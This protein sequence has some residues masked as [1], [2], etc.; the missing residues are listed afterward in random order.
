MKY[1]TNSILTVVVL[2]LSFTNCMEDQDYKQD[3]SGF[4]RQASV[5]VTG[6]VGVSVIGTRS[7]ERVVEESEIQTSD[8]KYRIKM[9][10]K[11]AEWQALDTLHLRTA[12]GPD[13]N[14]TD[15]VVNWV[16][17]DAI[18]IY[19]RAT[20]GLP[21]IN[22]DRD[23][24]KYTTTSTTA[25]GSFTPSPYT[26]YYPPK[27][28]LNPVD[29]LAYYPYAYVTAPLDTSYSAVQ[30]ANAAAMSNYTLNYA[31]PTNQT[32]TRIQYADLMYATPV[33]NKV[34]S[35]PAVA[36]SFNHALSLFTFRFRST[37]F[38]GINL[39]KVRLQGTKV[40][41]TG[42]LNL[43]TPLL[44]ANTTTT[45]TP[46]SII[47][48][49]LNSATYIYED[50]IINPCSV[51]A[52]PAGQMTCVVTI[53]N[54]DYSL[55]IG[56][57]TFLSGRRYYA[58]I[59]VSNV[60]GNN[61]LIYVGKGG[62]VQIGETRLDGGDV[63]SFRNST[64]ALSAELTADA[65]WLPFRVTYD[66]STPVDLTTTSPQTYTIPINSITSKLVVYFRP[67]SWYPVSGL[68]VHYDG[69]YSGGFNT[70]N[71]NVST[72]TTWSDLSGYAR[73]GTLVTVG[74]TATSGWTGNALRLDGGNDKV[75]MLGTITN[76]YSMNFVIDIA[77]GTI[78]TDPRLIGPGASFPSFYMQSS[79]GKIAVQFSTLNGPILTN[80][81][82]GYV[83]PRPK[84]V[85]YTMTYDATTDLLKLY[86]NG[87]FVSQITTATNPTS[88]ATAYL[89]GINTTANSMKGD[90]YNYM[91][92]NRA[93][94]DSEVS[95]IYTLNQSRFG[96]VP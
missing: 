81:Q 74:F 86:V 24:Y 11:E 89:G 13:V 40:T 33:R 26:L 63:G 62:K 57:T 48:Q 51:T 60:Q 8:G 10:I 87:A 79:S 77:A 65:G 50:L 71:A 88:I 37:A 80:P 43:N 14:A 82:I 28:T 32:G 90:L 42:T 31:I 85:Q 95:A 92:Y 21:N 29:F 84:I 30:F 73:N 52:S 91:L 68:V 9:I 6:S 22:A 56:A 72:A 75:S 5:E 58:Y 66:N 61:V 4:N 12:W 18:G 2:L 46:Y 23:N 27:S 34:S 15:N 44:S 64:T 59:T 3:N 35:T 76:S 93:L 49:T 96:I 94:T 7:T 55:P 19:M 78:D 45:F 16:S 25:S 70:T 36:F 53:G 1:I 38:A 41:N 54:I 83:V 39:T 67:S 47:N 69:I 17:G 20:S